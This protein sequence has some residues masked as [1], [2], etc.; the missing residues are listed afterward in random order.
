MIETMST[1]DMIEEL[2]N[3]NK[4]QFKYIGIQ[5][6]TAGYRPEVESHLKF[7]KSLKLNPIKTIKI[8]NPRKNPLGIERK[9]II[10]NMENTYVNIYFL[11]DVINKIPGL[12]RE[13][14]IAILVYN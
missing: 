8:H 2:D 14:C 10:I 4:E 7:I 13:K 3:M 11:N 12:T 1:Q 9:F 6:N 5:Y